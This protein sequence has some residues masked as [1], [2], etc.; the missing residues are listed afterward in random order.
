MNFYCVMCFLNFILGI[1]FNC[2]KN[3][4][5][6]NILLQNVSQSM[7]NARFYMCTISTAQRMEL[8]VH[9]NTYS[10]TEIYLNRRLKIFIYFTK[11]VISHFA[12]YLYTIYNSIA[13]MFGHAN[14][15]YVVGV[16]C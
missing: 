14:E 5:L 2:K 13:F 12:N 3:K 4:F 11:N 1:S 10:I 9:P 15:E 16:Y 6:N 7:S 8:L